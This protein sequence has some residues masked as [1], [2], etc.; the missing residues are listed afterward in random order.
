MITAESVSW[1]CWT[2]SFY[3]DNVCTYP[4]WLGFHQSSLAG[5][6]C[7]VPSSLPLDCIRTS[8]LMFCLFP[9][10]VDTWSSWR[11]SSQLPRSCQ[12]KPRYRFGVPN[13]NLWGTS[14][15][16]VCFD[17]TSYAYCRGKKSSFDRFPNPGSKR[18]SSILSFVK[19]A[20]PS[21]NLFFLLQKGVGEEE[22]SQC[23]WE[24]ALLSTCPPL[25]AVCW[26]S[27]QEGTIRVIAL[28][29]LERLPL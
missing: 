2:S 21:T 9:G 20:L 12:R 10:F 22:M 14:S 27:A 23:C 4:A 7:H 8:K 25:H 5:A 29:L 18:F 1:C 19:R 24:K 16:P 26:T 11:P 28:N 13:F 6:N 17:S 15:S 3:L